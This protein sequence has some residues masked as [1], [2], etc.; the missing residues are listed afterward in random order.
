MLL[1]QIAYFTARDNI[2]LI[3]AYVSHVRILCERRAFD[4]WLLEN[5]CATQNYQ[6]IAVHVQCI[7]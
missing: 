6:I 1:L 2:V 3:A 5:G 7:A 4:K